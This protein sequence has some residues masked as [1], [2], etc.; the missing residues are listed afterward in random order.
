MGTWILIGGVPNVG[1]STII[2]ALRKKDSETLKHTKKSGAR[3]GGQPC[4]TKSF[5]GFRVSSDP[6]VYIVDS[7]GI[8]QPKIRE[9]SEDG[10]KL[11]AVNCIRDGIIE[12]ELVCDYVLFKLNRER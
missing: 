4:L 5:S 6:P 12:P 10:L 1:K 9:E 11:S 7:P 2:N 8:I 3:T